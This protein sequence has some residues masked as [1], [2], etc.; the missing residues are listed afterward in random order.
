MGV[1]EGAYHNDAFTRG[2]HHVSNEG[3]SPCIMSGKK[4]YGCRIACLKKHLAAF[5]SRQDGVVFSEK[6]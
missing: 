2:D 5:N 3:A 4:S 6:E 1:S